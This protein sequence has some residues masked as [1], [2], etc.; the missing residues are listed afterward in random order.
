MVA[1]KMPVGHRRSRE[2]DAGWTPAL[3]EEEDAGWT[4]ALQEEEKTPSLRGGL[5]FS[6]LPGD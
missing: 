2:E 3:P 1:P 6:G 5:F 4:P